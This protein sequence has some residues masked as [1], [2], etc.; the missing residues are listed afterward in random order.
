M[1]EQQAKELG[2]VGPVEP[3]W[4]RELRSRSS[5]GGFAESPLAKLWAKADSPS[6]S[7]DIARI[8]EAHKREAPALEPEDEPLTR[9]T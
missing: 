9:D 7:D 8:R 6:V 2:R 3:G 5:A 1:E 4:L